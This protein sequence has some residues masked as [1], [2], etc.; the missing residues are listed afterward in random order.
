MIMIRIVL[1]AERIGAQVMAGN[2]SHD[3]A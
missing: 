1:V 2:E 3:E